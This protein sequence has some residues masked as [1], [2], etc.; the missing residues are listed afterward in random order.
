[1]TGKFFSCPQN[2]L[3]KKEKNRNYPFK[4]SFHG[5]NRIRLF[6]SPLLSSEPNLAVSQTLSGLPANPE[7]F[8][9]ARKQ[10]EEEGGGASWIPSPPD[11]VSILWFVWHGTVSGY[12]PP[13]I[14][15]WRALPG[16]WKNEGLCGRKRGRWG[17][18][19]MRRKMGTRGGKK[20]GRERKT[21]R[22]REM[23][24]S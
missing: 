2:P 11:R 6:W 8:C 14:N 20:R 9:S 4:V 1:M 12:N 22:E 21:E 7:L 5:V 17:G 15:I 19:I 18:T 3:W 13:M 16:H 24:I 23:L 10:E